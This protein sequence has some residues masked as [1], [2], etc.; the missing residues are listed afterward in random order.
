ML[1]QRQRKLAAVA[2]LTT[3]WFYSVATKSSDGQARRISAALPSDVSRMPS[4]SNRVAQTDFDNFAWQTF[5]ALNWPTKDGHLDTH[6]IIGQNP[7]A[8]RVW[9]LFTDPI[10][11]LKNQANNQILNLS[12]PAGSKLLYLPRKRIE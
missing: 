2:V 11:I 3:V 7:Q 4:K 10:T 5:V 12:V 6:H 8:P 9:E 1:G